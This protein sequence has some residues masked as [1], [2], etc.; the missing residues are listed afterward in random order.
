[1]LAATCVFLAAVA[2]IP[3]DGPEW[4]KVIPAF[5]AD[6]EH[7][8]VNIPRRCETAPDFSHQPDVCVRMEG[9]SPRI[10]LDGKP[11]PF[12]CGR[13][14]TAHRKEH[15]PRLADLPF[16]VVTVD[17]IYWPALFPKTGTV[18]TNVL[19]KRAALFATYS[20][21]ATAWITRAVLRA[22]LRSMRCS[23]S[24]VYT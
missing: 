19:M 6:A 5:N 12:F 14:N 3:Y 2:A 11:F 4:P 17:N 9:G 16:N 23:S 8:A 10:F 7:V 21:R 20:F 1:M 22:S 24:R 18:N 15:L 13:I